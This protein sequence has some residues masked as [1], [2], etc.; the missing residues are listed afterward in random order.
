MESF[1]ILDLL[2]AHKVSPKGLCPSR[3]NLFAIRISFHSIRTQIRQAKNLRFYHLA[4]LHIKK[5]S[6]ERILSGNVSL[7]QS[8]QLDSSIQ[9]VTFSHLLNGVLPYLGFAP[10]LGEITNTAPRIKRHRLRLQRKSYNFR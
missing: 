2:H 1:P 5:D 9:N 10:P 6:S 7:E 4:N 8:S 3:L